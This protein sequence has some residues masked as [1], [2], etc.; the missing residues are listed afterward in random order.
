[1][2]RIKF[3]ILIFF[4]FIGLGWVGCHRINYKP[5]LKAIEAKDQNPCD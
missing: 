4:P 3:L 1:M 5:Y 2:L